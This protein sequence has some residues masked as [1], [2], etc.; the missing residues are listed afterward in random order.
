MAER[1]V[2]DRLGRAGWEVI[3]R[4]LRVGR[5]EIDILAVDPGPPRSLVFVEVRSAT[6][7]RFGLPEERVDRRKV[8][9]LYRAAAAARTAGLLPGGAQVLRL[10]WRVDLVAV[11]AVPTLAAGVGGSVVR[12]LRDVRAD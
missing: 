1:L 3:G 4:S 6:D 10:P 8:R 12:H 9:H 11:E 5:D 7:T 2:A